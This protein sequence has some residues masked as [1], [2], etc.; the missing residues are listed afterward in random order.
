MRTRISSVLV[1][2]LALLLAGCAAQSQPATSP[3][4][5]APAAAAPPDAAAATGNA[6][7]KVTVG[8]SKAQVRDA[9]GSP[10]DENSYASGKAWIPFYYGNDI[11]R[12]TWYYK[13]QGRVTFADGN[14]FGGGRSEVINVEIDPSEQ[15]SN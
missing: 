12:T 14:Q 2:G 7:S 4:E 15:G 3:R 13:G 6:L 5:A 1:C 11:R 9:V 8:M 10:S